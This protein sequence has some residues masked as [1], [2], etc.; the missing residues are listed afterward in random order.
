M[1]TLRNYMHGGNTWQTFTVYSGT[2]TKEQIAAQEC[3]YRVANRTR[4]YRRLFGVDLAALQD[5]V[6]Q[7]VERAIK[8]ASDGK[9]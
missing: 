3:A 8:E 6:R 1:N 5:V 7:E 9:A 2:W 4:E